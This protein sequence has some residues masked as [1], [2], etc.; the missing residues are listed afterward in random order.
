M[1]SFVG[2]CLIVYR[3]IDFSFCY[4]DGKTKQEDR[5]LS[6]LILNL[7]AFLIFFQR[8]GGS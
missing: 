6:A 2:L 1:S 4:M 3:V 7:T 8:D 5:A